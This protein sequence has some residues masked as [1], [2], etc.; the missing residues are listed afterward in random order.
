[1]RNL[2]RLATSLVALFM[3]VAFS[4]CE[5]QQ[6]DEKVGAQISFKI[7]NPLMNGK[8]DTQPST[9]AP[10]QCSDEQAD[11]VRVLIGADWYILDM[12]SEGD[13]T[14][15]EALQLPVGDYD[16]NEFL[17]YSDVTGDGY[18]MDDIL[19]YASPQ[20]GSVYDLAFD[21][22][23]NVMQTFT[24]GDFQKVKTTID[25]VCFT[26]AEYTAFGFVHFNYHAFEVH[27]VCFFGDICSKFWEEWSI[28][29]GKGNLYYG[30]P[31][32]YDMYGYF[33][34]TMTGLDAQGQT[35]ITTTNN[36]SADPTSDDFSPKDFLVCVDFLDDLD[37][38]PMY[39]ETWEFVITMKLPDGSTLPV[40]TVTLSD[41]PDANNYWENFGGTDGVYTWVSGDCNYEGNEIEATTD[42]VLFLPS[43][44]NATI[45]WNLPLPIGTLDSYYSWDVLI[46]TMVD[47]DN[48]LYPKEFK[49][50]ITI[51]A[52]C[53]DLYHTISGTQDFD[54]YRTDGAYANDVPSEYLGYPL[55]QINWL[56]N[57]DDAILESGAQGNELQ[58][59][60]WLLIHKGDATTSTE[61]TALKNKIIGHTSIA[62]EVYDAL[63]IQAGIILG[64]AE[65]AAF[66]PRT[67][68]W[69][70]VLLDPVESSTEKMMQLLIIRVDP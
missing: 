31:T 42:P 59:L 30:W 19:V 35:L 9:V 47:G 15:T 62:P 1:M 58:A 40:S 57:Q 48:V 41:D 26:P 55:A 50:G 11:Y 18:T 65:I 25:V 12:L 16:V 61:E 45:T 60:M 6:A 17:V 36:F 28:Y 68:D 43:Q 8:K 4:S 5:K 63:F 22:D 34:V 38:D 51:G 23:K 66:T 27:T 64:D 2:K 3:V 70:A 32:H 29:N 56:A 44:I 49:E 46:N 54:V 10:P 7:D 39:P 33:E 20:E 52:Y 13:G 53:G 37:S 69:T 24:L 14:S 21:F 67:G